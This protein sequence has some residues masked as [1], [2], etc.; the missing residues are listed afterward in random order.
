MNYI[1]GYDFSN[2]DNVDVSKLPQGTGLVALRAIRQNGLEDITFQPR[3]HALRDSR[4]EI[5]RLSYLFFNWYKPG[6]IQAQSIL[7]LGINFTEAGNGPIC[8][9][10][11]ADSDSGIEAYIIKNRAVCIGLVND[12]ISYLRSSSLYGRQDIIIYSN[13]SFLRDT[14]AHTWPDTLFWLS[15]Y[16]HTLPTNPAQPVLIW[17]YAEYGKLDR[18][19]TDFTDKSGSLDLDYFVGT[20]ADLDKLANR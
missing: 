2:L 6:E 7:K 19:V 5:V 14:I 18:T 8:I 12:C 4:P 13:D 3:Y 1:N 17:Q 10:L 20:Q 16:Q 11:E 9:D 15:S